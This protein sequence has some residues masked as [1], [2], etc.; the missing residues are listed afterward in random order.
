[1]NPYNLVPTMSPGAVPRSPP[2]GMVS[3]IQLIPATSTFGGGLTTTDSADAR[4]LASSRPLPTLPGSQP[5]VPGVEVAGGYSGGMKRFSPAYVAITTGGNIRHLPDSSVRVNRSRRSPP[6]RPV[7][8]IQQIPATGGGL[9][10]TNGADAGTLACS[11]VSSTNSSSSA[12]TEEDGQK[13]EPG[14][15]N[16]D[17]KMFD[18]DLVQISTK[19]LNKK[20]KKENIVKG[21]ARKIKARRRTL[22]N[23]G[24][25]S[26]CRVSRETEEQIFEAKIKE[27]QKEIDDY[28]PLECL[29]REAALLEKDVHKL[30]LEQREEEAEDTGFDSS[31]D[32]ATIADE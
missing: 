31:S 3:A 32:S 12:S 28:P 17:V 6:Y 11:V 13:V 22:K 9:I 29:E 1:M 5:H 15:W 2:Y 25:A 8:A 21:E 24:Y 4:A 23:R 26:Q 30:K 18:A 27:L 10:S 14:S 19:E 16:E 20:L 7:S